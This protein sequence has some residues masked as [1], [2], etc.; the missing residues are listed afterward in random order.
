MAEE[1]TAA[2]Q[3]DSVNRSVYIDWSLIG[4]YGW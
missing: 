1:I 4:S 3:A 2:Y